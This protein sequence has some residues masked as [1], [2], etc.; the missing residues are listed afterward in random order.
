[1]YKH[2][3]LNI[4]LAVHRN[5]KEPVHKWPF[6]HIPQMGDQVTL[7]NRRFIVKFREFSVPQHADDLHKITIWVDRI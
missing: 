1:M 5:T 7:R 6:K 3:E 4:V 2:D